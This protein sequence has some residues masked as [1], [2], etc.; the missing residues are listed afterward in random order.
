MPT[1]AHAH[2]RRC[3]RE[4]RYLERE[5]D[6]ERDRRVGR[7]RARVDRLER[8]YRELEWQRERQR[9]YW[10]AL[11]DEQER[12]AEYERELMGLDWFNEINERYAREIE[13]G[14]DCDCQR[15]IQ[16]RAF[17]PRLGT[18]RPAKREA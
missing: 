10:Q 6:I 13:H 9:F 4:R 18:S 5:L 11:F 8:E 16:I 1:W 15:C 2:A 3:A 14:K 17:V 12:C 7:D